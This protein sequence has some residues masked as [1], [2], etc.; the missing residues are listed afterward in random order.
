MVHSWA[1]AK[2]GNN[3][4]IRTVLFDYRKAF[5]LIDHRILIHKLSKFI[6]PTRIINSI[7]DF[8]SGRSQRIKL[9]EGCY[10][11]WGSVPSRVPQ[12]TKLGP[13]LLLLLI[14]D[15]SLN[16][17]F[18]AQLWKYVDDTTTSEVIAKGGASNAQHIAD[19]HCELERVHKRALLIICPSLSYDEALNEAGI[20]TIISYCEDICDKVFNAALGNKD[21]KLNKL[22]TEANKAP[23]L[24]RNHRHFALPKW[25]T[26]RF[27]NTFILSSCL[28]YN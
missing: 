10:S 26:D 22:L 21:N 13:W 5:D 19:L 17:N 6:L 9:A 1:Q 23:Y 3:A 4:T 8:L 15:L 20:L 16:G 14:N 12:G 24:L 28:K 7:I 11:K 18:N 2:D 27:K 25:K